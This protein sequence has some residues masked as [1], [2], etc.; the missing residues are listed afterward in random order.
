MAHVAKVFRQCEG[1]KLA[2]GGWVAG[3]A[4]FGSIPCCCRG[5]DMAQCVFLTFIVKQNVQYCPLQVIK[6]LLRTR[7]PKRPAGAML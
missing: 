7:Y 5:K 3:K 6:K 4:W 1:A 2:D